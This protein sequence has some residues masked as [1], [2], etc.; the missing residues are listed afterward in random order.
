[1]KEPSLKR[2]IQIAL[3]EI[4]VRVAWRKREEEKLK[5]YLKG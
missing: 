5:D 1:M 3:G 4:T 2:N